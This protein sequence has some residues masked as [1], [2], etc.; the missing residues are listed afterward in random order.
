M[1]TLP[2]LTTTFGAGSSESQGDYNDERPHEALDWQTLAREIV[3]AL[4]K[5]SP[6]VLKSAS[7][8]SLKT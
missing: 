7:T 3:K 1:E 4:V 8:V 5:E 2:E 6:E